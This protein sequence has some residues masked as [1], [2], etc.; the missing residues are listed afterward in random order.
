MHRKWKLPAL[1]VLTGVMLLATNGLLL[2]G[3]GHHEKH[4][5]AN[6]ATSPPQQQQ[7]VAISP[8]M[9]WRPEVDELS[10]SRVQASEKF[11]AWL[12]EDFQPAK[13][14]FVARG[15]ANSPRTAVHVAIDQHLLPRLKETLRLDRPWKHRIAQRQLSRQLPNSSAIVE[16]YQESFFRSVDDSEH[17]AFTREATL[18][19]A[20]D[21]HLQRIARDIRHRIH[22]VE[23]ARTAAFAFALIAVL[24][25]LFV[26]WLLSRILNSVTRGYYVW[27]IRLGTATLMLLAMGVTAGITV[28][29]LHAV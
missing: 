18:I 15:V 14:Q 20:G 11:P 7:D 4:D 19:D 8:E 24:V 9:A 2:A 13:N 26:C 22:R 27:P 5:A 6:H 25:I 1:H 12:E 29:I 10:W 16:S 23:N 21:E 28:S 3:P 17:E